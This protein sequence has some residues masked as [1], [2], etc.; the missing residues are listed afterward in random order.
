MKR[1]GMLPFPPMTLEPGG[2]SSVQLTHSVDVPRRE[3]VQALVAIARKLEGAEQDAADHGDRNGG[4]PAASRGRRRKA[5][6]AT[7]KAAAGRA[8]RN[9]RN[10][11]S[12]T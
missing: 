1:H 9:T 12:P 6:R 11:T 7:K 8:N 4:R 3:G 2:A 10:S 5:S